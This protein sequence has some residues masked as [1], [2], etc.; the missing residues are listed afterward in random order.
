MVDVPG[1]PPDPRE[2]CRY[3]PDREYNRRHDVDS[4]LAT[5]F[6]WRRSMIVAWHEVTASLHC[7]GEEETEL[8]TDSWDSDIAILHF[9][10][11]QHSDPGPI[12][13]YVIGR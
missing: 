11:F 12:L 4:G 13:R 6:C 8:N 10:F 5:S 9:V 1:L 7:M 2:Q 3:S